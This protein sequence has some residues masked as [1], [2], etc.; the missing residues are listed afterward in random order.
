MAFS[1]LPS[2]AAEAVRETDDVSAAAETE[3]GIT[4]HDGIE[5]ENLETETVSETETAAEASCGDET[6]ILETG[7]PEK[8]NPNVLTFENEDDAGKYFK[9]VLENTDGFLTAGRLKAEP[10]EGKDLVHLLPAWKK[11]FR[12]RRLTQCFP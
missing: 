2:Y 4:L 11:H 9:V 1:S 7:T 3:P 6:G 8:S 10:A 12:A 5:T